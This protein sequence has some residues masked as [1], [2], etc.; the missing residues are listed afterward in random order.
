VGKNETVYISWLIEL[1][2]F[3]QDSPDICYMDNV[4]HS[5]LSVVGKSKVNFKTKERPRKIYR[6]SKIN[7]NQ[8]SKR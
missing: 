1:D 5:L 7:E 3:Y 8:A 2:Y 4:H 6:F